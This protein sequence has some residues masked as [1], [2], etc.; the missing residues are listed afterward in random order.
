[1]EVTI[2]QGVDLAAARKIS[3]LGETEKAAYTN[4]LI[5]KITQYAKKIFLKS[6][7]PLA[8]VA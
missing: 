2:P 5:T 7:I 3:T 6:K 1:M 4:A 8:I